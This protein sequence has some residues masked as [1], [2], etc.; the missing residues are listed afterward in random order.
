MKVD[1]K[2]VL[3]CGAVLPNRLAKSAMSE[4]MANPP[5]YPGSEFYRAYKAWVE[6][7]TGLIISV[8][9]GKRRYVDITENGKRVLVALDELKI[10][11]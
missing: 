5:F 3:P 10:L 7:G 9:D 11:I 6:G 2:C 4:N 8:I 1:E